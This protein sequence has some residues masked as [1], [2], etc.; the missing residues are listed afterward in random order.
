MK[1][2]WTKTWNVQDGKPYSLGGESYLTNV[3]ALNYYPTVGTGN[4]VEL[5]VAAGLVAARIQLFNSKTSAKKKTPDGM[6]NGSKPS[7]PLKKSSSL[8]RILDKNTEV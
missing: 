6:Q 4:D 5:V 2:L 1:G 7:Q 3:T 8:E